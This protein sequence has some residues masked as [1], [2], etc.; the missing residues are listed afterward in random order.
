MKIKGL[1]LIA[2]EEF[3]KEH[4]GDGAWEKVLEAL[5][6]A[7]QEFLKGVIFSVKWYPFEIGERL[8]NAIVKVLGHGKSAVF[9][10]LGVKSAQRS[11]AREH[12]SLLAPGDPQSFLK[13]SDVIYRL[14][15]DTGYREYQE[16]GPNSGVIT[17]YEAKTF[18]IPDCLTVIGWHKEALKLCGA[19]EGQM[20]EEECRAKGG[21]CC[22]YR[23]QWKI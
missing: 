23:V 10:E 8:D 18:S 21:K 5:P 7:D 4:F 12:K 19:K 22:R 17:T 15:Y 14:Y 1:V 9:E 2:R 13:R 11:L 3:V 16:T 6:V 20:V